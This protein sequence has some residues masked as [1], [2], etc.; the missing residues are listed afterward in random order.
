PHQ[1]RFALI[2]DPD[3]RELR[4]LEPS[5]GERR[6]RRREL[7]RPNLFGIVLDPTGLRV[8]LLNLSLRESACLSICIEDDRARARRPLIECEQ[9][10]CHVQSSGRKRSKVWACV[11]S[12]IAPICNGPLAR[13]KPC[14]IVP[15][16]RRIYHSG[17]MPTTPRL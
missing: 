7:R 11:S 13:A 17:A 12:T 6:A 1:R 16:I 14:S 2:G 15:R 3:C 9:E 8:R 10:M 5:V 4:R